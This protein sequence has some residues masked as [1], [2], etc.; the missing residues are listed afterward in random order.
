MN[1]NLYNINVLKLMSSHFTSTWVHH[2]NYGGVC[3]ADLFPLRNVCVI[4]FVT[5]E[6]RRV[7]H[8]EQ[9]LSTLPEHLNSPQL[10]SL[11][12]YRSN[13][14]FLCS[15]LQMT[16]VCLY[17]FGH[18]LFFFGVLGNKKS[19]L[20]L[21]PNLIYSFFITFLPM[22]STCRYQLQQV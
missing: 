21:F 8:V 9:K 17:S 14:S 11:G 19:Q 22:Q 16:F 10:L 5:R 2:M 18:C 6:T 13:F 15:A 12:S 1:R 20:V 7:P 3:V 4:G